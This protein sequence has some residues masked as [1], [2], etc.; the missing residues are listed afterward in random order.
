MHEMACNFQTFSFFFYRP[1]SSVA[2][3]CS[4]FKNFG[5]PA[6]RCNG[7]S[8]SFDRET[9]K[10]E[11]KCRHSVKN[12]VTRH[13][14]DG[15]IFFETTLAPKL[16]NKSFHSCKEF[17]FSFFLERK[18]VAVERDQEEQVSQVICKYIYISIN[19]S[20]F[21]QYDI[22]VSHRFSRIKAIDPHIDNRIAKIP[23]SKI[24]YV[25][26]LCPIQYR[27]KIRC[28]IRNLIHNHG[29]RGEPLVKMLIISM[30]SNWQTKFII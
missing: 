2:Q 3:L 20:T 22:R 12:V 30:A 8:A 11:H 5:C 15:G 18:K 9:Y 16:K 26:S 14:R 27:C 7:E 6:R 28:L 17:C 25:Q 23:R 4:S 19:R 13:E 24:V 29:V 21:L 1:R 10:G